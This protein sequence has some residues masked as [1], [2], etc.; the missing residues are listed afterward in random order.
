MLSQAA[1]DVA[2]RASRQAS[3]S[4]QGLR[5]MLGRRYTHD[6][7]IFAVADLLEARKLERCAPGRY[8]IVAPSR[9]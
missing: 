5:N 6:E 3:V 4:L 2:E 7:L 1:A 9:R 8:R